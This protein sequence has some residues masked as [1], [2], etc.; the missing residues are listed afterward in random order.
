MTGSELF[1]ESMR[2]AEADENAALRARVA[3]AEGGCGEHVAY[4]VAIGKAL[5]AED[6]E[7]PL[8]AA[9]RVMRKLE[10]ATNLI[11]HTA[12][13][14]AELEEKLHFEQDAHASLHDIYEDSLDRVAELEQQ[15]AA[16]SMCSE[17][18]KAVQRMLMG[19]TFPEAIL[20]LEKQVAALADALEF[21]DQR[22][23][24]M[25]LSSSG[26]TRDRIRA[27]LRAAGRK[28]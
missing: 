16:S 17:D 20:R 6:E 19:E 9:K 27:A 15:V 2:R 5:D 1:D 11:A 24:D 25:G 3:A 14:V 22:L 13:R 7:T 28:T 8:E 10:A 4:A 26:T 18:A 21:A 23:D 12:A